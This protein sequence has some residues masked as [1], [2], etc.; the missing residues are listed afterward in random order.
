MLSLALTDGLYVHANSEV[1]LELDFAE[2]ADLAARAL[3]SLVDDHAR[4]AAEER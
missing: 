1:H 4:R 3:E 2:Y